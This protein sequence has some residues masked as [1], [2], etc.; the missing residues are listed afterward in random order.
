MKSGRRRFLLTLP[1]V[2]CAARAWAAYPEVNRGRMLTFPRDHGAH[3]MYRTEWWYITGWVRDASGGDRG[4]QITFFRNR[5]QVQED[6]PSAFAPKQLVFA[7]A[8]VGDAQLGMLRHDQRVAREGLGLAGAATGSTRV[9][10]EDWSLQLTREGYVAQVV[11]RNF[12]MQ[13]TFRA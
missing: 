8:A 1:P 10:I 6:N 11:A 4:V 5:P 3:P 7:H 2:V 12:R 9:W 13:L